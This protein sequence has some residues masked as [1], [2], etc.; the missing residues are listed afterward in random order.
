MEVIRVAGWMAGVS[1]VVSTQV[2]V[3]RRPSV[4]ASFVG[5]RSAA[6]ASCQYRQVRAHAASLTPTPG[7]PS[8]SCVLSERGV[9]LCLFPAVFE[10]GEHVVDHGLRAVGVD[11]IDSGQMV[12]KA[13]E[14]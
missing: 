1:A 14:L 13:F 6:I 8:A 2:E 9:S 7:L 11:A 5:C 4:L 10:R 12:A 3:I